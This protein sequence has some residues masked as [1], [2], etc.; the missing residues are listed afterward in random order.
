VRL[1]TTLTAIV[2]LAVATPIR[3]ANDVQL[4]KGRLFQSGSYSIQTVGALNETGHAIGYL[5][6]ECG[7]FR[8]GQLVRS[9]GGVAQ[10]IKLGQRAYFDVRSSDTPDADSTECRISDIVPRETSSGA[11]QAVAPPSWDQILAIRAATMALLT[12]TA[13]DLA[14]ASGKPPQVFLDALEK[15]SADAIRTAGISGSDDS[16]AIR[17]AAQ[18]RLKE[19]FTGI[20]F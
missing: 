4:T 1:K 9:G 12:V 18:D 7:F 20:H 8:H 6:V 17:Q 11:P 14:K 2:C 5:E 15:A 13:I 16:D 19:L 3:A 10:N